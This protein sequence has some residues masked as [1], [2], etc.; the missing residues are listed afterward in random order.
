MKKILFAGFLLALLSFAFT[1]NKTDRTITGTIKDENGKPVIGATIK[2]KGT[3]IASTS[4]TAGN[5]T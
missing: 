4:D 2:A 5:F 1:S 3:N